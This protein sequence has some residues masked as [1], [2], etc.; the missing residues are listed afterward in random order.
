MKLN[1]IE[2]WR[3]AHKFVSVQIQGGIV[4]LAAAWATI[5]Q[6]WRDAVPKSVLV[7]LAVVFALAT[8]FGRVVK[9]GGDNA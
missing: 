8:V 7:V 2:E 5:P 1:L 3:Q 4:A 9:Q 6:E